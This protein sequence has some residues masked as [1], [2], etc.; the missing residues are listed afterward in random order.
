MIEG[1]TDLGI[2]NEPDRTPFDYA[3]DNE[4]LRKPT[5]TGG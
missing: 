3:K 1:G 2:R 4:A 5:S